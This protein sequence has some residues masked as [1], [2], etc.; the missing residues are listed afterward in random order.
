MTYRSYLSFT[1]SLCISGNQGH[2]AVRDVQPVPVGGR[3]H[4]DPVA[5][6]RHHEV[7]EG[8]V[9]AIGKNLIR[10]SSSVYLIFL[11]H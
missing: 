8:P 11:I 5:E 2:Q 3:R 7:Q 1:I 10:S 9:H 4:L 6:H